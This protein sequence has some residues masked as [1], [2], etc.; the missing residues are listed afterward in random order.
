MKEK[1]IQLLNQKYVDKIN[2]LK[3]DITDYVIYVDSLD[4]VKPI[5]NDLIE[6]INAGIIDNFCIYYVNTLQEYKVMFSVPYGWQDGID[7]ILKV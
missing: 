5:N 3:S 2:F 4:A 7:R 6:F 1:L